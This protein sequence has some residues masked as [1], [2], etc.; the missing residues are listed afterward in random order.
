MIDIQS[1]IFSG[2]GGKGSSFMLAFKMDLLPTSPE[3]DKNIK[4][5]L[6]RLVSK[7]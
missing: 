7:K 6:K 2:M 1:K 5:T 4:I 3:N